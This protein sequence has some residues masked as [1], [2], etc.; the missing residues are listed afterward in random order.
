MEEGGSLDQDA[1]GKDAFADAVGRVQR[2][3]GEEQLGIASVIF[4]HLIHAKYALIEPLSEEGRK[5]IQERIA[6]IDHGEGVPTEEAQIFKWPQS[7]DQDAAGKDAF[8]D[9]VGR[10]QRRAGDEQG[11]MA[12]IIFALLDEH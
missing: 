7:L 10:E 4:A 12:G 5:A 8:A 3:S 11:D 2:R 1:A 6:S 9:A